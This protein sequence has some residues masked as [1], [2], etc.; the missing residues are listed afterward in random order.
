MFFCFC[1]ER[2]RERERESHAI[3]ASFLLSPPLRV[4]PILSTAL[5]G[6]ISSL[7]VTGWRSQ[8]GH[9]EG[10][11]KAPEMAKTVSL[12]AERERIAQAALLCARTLFCV[13]PIL[14]RALC[15]SPE[16]HSRHHGPETVENRKLFGLETTALA[17]KEGKKARIPT[18]NSGCHPPPTVDGMAARARSLLCL[19]SFAFAYEKK[20][21][22]ITTHRARA[23]AD[24]SLALDSVV[25]GLCGARLQGAHRVV[26]APGLG[27]RG[28]RGGRRG[29]S[30]ALLLPAQFPRRPRDDAADLLQR[31]EEQREA[32]DV[33]QHDGRDR[34]LVQRH[35]AIKRG[36]RERGSR[37]SLFPLKRG[38]KK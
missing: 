3:R 7:S 23:A 14:S 37:S 10:G 9:E 16:L 12:D 35:G 20:T 30:C 6:N 38:G 8:K 15:G 17:C 34:D 31:V 5:V 11:E 24:P 33:R 13:S 27:G 32:D 29:R 1:Q 2:E 21:S 28:G 4:L 26:D 36:K 18:R 19:S 22:T 25:D